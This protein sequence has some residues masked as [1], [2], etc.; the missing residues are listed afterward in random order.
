M[1]RILV[2]DDEPLVAMLTAE[3]VAD[4]GHAPVGPAHTLGAALELV[5]TDDIDGAIIDVSLGRETAY[6]LAEVL[7]ARSIPFAFATGHAAAT[8]DQ[9]YPAV[10][11]LTKPFALKP[12]E[13]AMETIVAHS[14]RP[15]APAWAGVEAQNN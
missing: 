7:A 4:F 10:A 9:S 3:W 13:A 14:G 1:A 12:F 6:P 5:R 2:V 15:G 11:V 8:L